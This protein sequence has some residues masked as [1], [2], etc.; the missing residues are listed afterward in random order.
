MSFGPGRPQDSASTPQGASATT[1]DLLKNGVEPFPM[2]LFRES[3]GCD[4][5]TSMA[6]A[7]GDGALVAE[8]PLSGH[9]PPEPR[10][11]VPDRP[12]SW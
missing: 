5:P 6:K 8:A 2:A 4:A 3:P 10:V 1:T 11:A 7:R 9:S 12:R